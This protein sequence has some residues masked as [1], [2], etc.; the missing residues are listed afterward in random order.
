MVKA[1]FSRLML[2]ILVSFATQTRADQA[3]LSYEEFL[4]QFGSGSSQSDSDIIERRQAL[5]EAGARAQQQFLKDSAER[6][7][8]LPGGQAQLAF[9]Y[10]Q[11]AVKLLGEFEDEGDP[12]KLK[13]ALNAA[14]SAIRLDDQQP[15]YWT[16]L[17]LIHTQ[18]SALHILRSAE[19]AEDAFVR[20]LDLEPADPTVMVLLADRLHERGAH[21]EALFLFET[22]VLSDPTLL[23]GVIKQMT[24]AY[25]V[26]P[27]TARG[28]E[29][30]YDLQ[31]RRLSNSD[32]MFYSPY[33][34][35]YRAILLNAMSEH[36]E[37]EYA[38]DMLLR[39]K[40]GLNNYLTPPL[41][42]NAERLLE[43]TRKMKEAKS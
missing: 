6:I 11:E 15:E 26:A 19:Y 40:G 23:P 43:Q 4:L 7:A 36:G 31:F 9:L 3:P 41:R 35:W 32:E 25:L 33:I 13:W 17:G 29:F 28:A 21:K 18:N 24:T 1:I 38:L 34:L 37:A 42:E 14:G 30:F 2:L 22:A 39:T 8:S 10:H 27:L 12:E 5:E 20:S 16:N